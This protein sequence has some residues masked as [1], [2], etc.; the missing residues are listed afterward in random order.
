VVLEALG[1][2]EAQTQRLALNQVVVVV[3]APQ[4]MQAVRVETARQ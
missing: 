1:L 3:V 2:Q 4:Y